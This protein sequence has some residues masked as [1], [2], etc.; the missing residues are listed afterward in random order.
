MNVAQ[1]AAES[2]LSE[3]EIRRGVANGELACIYLGDRLLRVTQRDW[4]AFMAR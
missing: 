3:S 1:C 4:E 2:S